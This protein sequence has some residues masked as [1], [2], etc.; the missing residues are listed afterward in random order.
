M[1]IKLEKETQKR[2]VGSIKRFYAEEMEDEIGDLKTMRLL[3]FFLRELGPNIYN[4]AIADAQ[5]YFLDKAEDL[6]DA[7]YVPEFDF[8]KKKLT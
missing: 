6:G 3:E 7:Y 4:Q 2:L 8:W 5:K 1:A